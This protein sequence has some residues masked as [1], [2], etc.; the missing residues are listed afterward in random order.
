MPDIGETLRESRMRRRIDMAEVEAATKIRA[1]YLRALENEEW[2]LLPGPTFVKSFLR[3]YAEYLELDARTLVEDYKQRFEGTAATEP[4]AFGGLAG[5]RRQQR[6]P[7]RGRTRRRSTMAAFGPGLAVGIGVVALLAIFYLLGVLGQED[8]ELPVSSTPTP[9]ATA[10]ATATAT[11]AGTEKER[12]STRVRL[13]IVATG[14]VYVCLVDG[15]GR[16]LLDGVTL[17][18]GERTRRFTSRRLLA[19]FGT[20]TVRMRVDDR[21]WPVAESANPVGYELRPGRKPRRLPDAQR[22]DCS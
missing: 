6:P 14:D 22:P 13:A 19:N 11:P 7:P 20:S 17:R 4:A 3:T 5:P 12:M 9:T 1:K 16:R 2:E 21:T 18:K 10:V 8:T 15:T